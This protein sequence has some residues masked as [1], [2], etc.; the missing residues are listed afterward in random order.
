MAKKVFHTKKTEKREREKK[1]IIPSTQVQHLCFE[2]FLFSF[3][4]LAKSETWCQFHHVPFNKE[5]LLHIRTNF[6]FTCFTNFAVC[7]FV[8]QMPLV[9]RDF[10]SLRFSNCVL[11]LKSDELSL[12]YLRIFAQTNGIKPQK[13]RFLV[14]YGLVICI[15]VRD[16]TP[17]NN[18]GHWYKIYFFI[19]SY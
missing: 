6:I 5:N 15:Y 9:I 13:Q 14:I 12:G 19:I 10:D 1:H 11:N 2:H 17:T 7:L 16:V 4:G 8:I 18:E 3:V